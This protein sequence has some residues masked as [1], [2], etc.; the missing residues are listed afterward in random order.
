MSAGSSASARCGSASEYASRVRPRCPGAAC[1]RCRSPPRELMTAPVSRRRG[2]RLPPTRRREDTDVGAVVGERV[3]E[4]DGQFRRQLGL[5]RAADRQQR[6]VAL[7]DQIVRGER[8]ADAPAA[9]DDAKDVA[10]F[11]FLEH[12]KLRQRLQSVARRLHAFDQVAVDGPVKAR[13]PPSA[14]RRSRR[15]SAPTSASPASAPSRPLSQWPVSQ[16]R[17][18]RPHVGEQRKR[19]ERPRVP[20]PEVDRA[21]IDHAAAGRPPRQGWRPRRNSDRPGPST[22]ASPR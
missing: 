22:R 6:L 3:G 7:L 16:L 19:R 14:A 8:R 5:L 18:I 9:P 2:R 17:R 13:R 10:G 12:Q 11:E 20:R 21:A 15:G 1:R 4:T